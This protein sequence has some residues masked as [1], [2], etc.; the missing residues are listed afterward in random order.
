MINT[1]DIQEKLNNN[2]KDIY[3]L[4]QTADEQLEQL[5]Q[6]NKG[7]FSAI[8]QPTSG[9]YADSNRFLPYLVELSEGVQEIP[10]CNEDALPQHLQ[11]LVSKIRLMHKM[12]NQFHSVTGA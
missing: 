7:Q 9:F 4:A 5:S 6:N 10:Q 8:F 11:H 1:Q 12:L 3:P 2:L